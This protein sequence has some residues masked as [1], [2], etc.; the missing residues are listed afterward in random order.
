M[1]LIWTYFWEINP[2]AEK[3]NSK[4]KQIPKTTPRNQTEPQ[5]RE[6]QNSTKGKVGI[7]IITKRSMATPRT[8]KDRKW[9]M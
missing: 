1:L 8:K 3:S 2:K 9:G 7:N 5:Q 4:E 6:S